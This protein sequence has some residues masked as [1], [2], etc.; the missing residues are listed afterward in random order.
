MHASFWTPRAAVDGWSRAPRRLHFWTAALVLAGLAFAWIMVA[1]LL[2]DLLTKF[3]L[4]QL[5]KTIG[6]IALAFAAWRLIPR[7]RCVRPA[8]E[9][10]LW[11]GNGARLS[12]AALPVP[13][14]APH[15]VVAALVTPPAQFLEQPDQRQLRRSAPLPAGSCGRSAAGR[16]YAI[17]WCHRR[18]SAVAPAAS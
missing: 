5:H 15:R 6:L 9:M 14:I 16:H 1:V 3:Q 4:F 13:G 7:A 12:L 8:M 18:N 2:R 10:G 17:P 11:R